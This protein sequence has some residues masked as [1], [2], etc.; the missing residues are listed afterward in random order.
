MRLC[1]YFLLLAAL[2]S[3]SYT[4]DPEKITA[5]TGMNATLPCPHKTGNAK[6]AKRG[7]ANVSFADLSKIGQPPNTNKS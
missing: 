1:L 6:P 3:I 4:A 5:L 2:S 7:S